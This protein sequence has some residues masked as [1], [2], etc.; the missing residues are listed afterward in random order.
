[1]NTQRLSK[2][3]EATPSTFRFIRFLLIMT[4][5]IFCHPLPSFSFALFTH[6]AII[7]AS[8]KKTLIPLLKQ[9]YPGATA[10]DLKKAHAYVYGGAIIPDIG[11]YPLG[12]PFFTNLVHYVRSGDFITTI[13]EES[14]D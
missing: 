12:N 4:L 7:D 13:I 3:L 1:M 9:K 10:E 6:E 14:H 8:W 5:I 11:Y 2:S